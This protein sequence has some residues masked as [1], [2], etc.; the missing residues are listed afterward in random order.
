MKA[1]IVG[2]RSLQVDNIKAFLPTQ[3]TEI[4]SG[5]AKGVDFS[6]KVYALNNNIKYTEFLPQYSLYGK[7]APL[8]RNLQIIDYVD[9]VIAFWN[10]SS[11]GTKFIIDNCKKA[12]KPCKVFISK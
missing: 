7:S 11:N 1:A 9:I 4:I 5:G 3:T 2:S 8:K 12:G 10:G 6:A